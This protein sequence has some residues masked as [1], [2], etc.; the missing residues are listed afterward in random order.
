MTAVWK[1]AIPPTLCTIFLCILYIHFAT[2]EQVRSHLHSFIATL[3][4]PANIY[5]LMIMLMT[6]LADFLKLRK[7]RNF[8]TQP[9]RG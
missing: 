2:A 9:F 6:W 7:K 5:R 3:F 4:F 1:S 8:G